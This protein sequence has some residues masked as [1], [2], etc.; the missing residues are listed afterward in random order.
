M[1]SS[2]WLPQISSGIQWYYQWR[3]YMKCVPR[4]TGNFRLWMRIHIWCAQDNIYYSSRGT[5]KKVGKTLANPAFIQCWSWFL[6]DDGYLTLSSEQQT[7]S[8]WCK[9]ERQVPCIS[10]TASSKTGHL[11][12]CQKYT[13]T[14]LGYSEPVPGYWVKFWPN[15]TVLR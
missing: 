10:S 4:M 6:T 13:A 8:L 2:K 9:T 7:F 3:N 11:S 14:G 1:K 15:F 12:R 5:T